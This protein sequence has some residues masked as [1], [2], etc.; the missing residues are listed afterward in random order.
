MLAA[1]V[2][3][4]QVCQSGQKQAPSVHPAQQ[5]LPGKDQNMI[6]GFG[7]LFREFIVINMGIDVLEH[8]KTSR[9]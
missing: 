6:A 3:I 7:R 4:A 1:G 9:F 2:G 8:E 5:A